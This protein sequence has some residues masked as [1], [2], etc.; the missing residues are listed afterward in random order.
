MKRLQR[1]YYLVGV[2][3]LLLAL[4]A[5]FFF[6]QIASTVK[7][8]PH[9]QINYVIFA[10]IILGSLLMLW[11]VRR[12]NREGDLLRA[13]VNKVRSDGAGEDTR[14]WFESQ[15]D[16]RR[17]D[18]TD[19]LDLVLD[20]HGKPLGQVQ[21]AAIESELQYFH[22]RQ[23]R[24][25]LLAQFL[26]GMMVGMGLLGTFIGLLGALSEIGKLIGSFSI[27][28]SMGDPVEAV[29]LLVG[30][31]TEPMKAMGVAFSASLFGVLGSLIMGMLMVSVRGCMGEL[32]SIVQSRVSWMTDLP[33]D[34]TSE[35]LTNALADLAQHSPLLSG[36]SVALDQSERRVRQ[37]IETITTLSAA[38]EVSGKSQEQIEKQLVAQSQNQ[39]A[40]LDVLRQLSDSQKEAVAI[41]ERSD[42][43]AVEAT[44]LQAQ[45]LTLLQQALTRH[46]PWRETIA[47]LTQAQA[48]QT[49]QMQTR[50]TEGLAAMVEQVR[51]ERT[52]WMGQE[53]AAA[54]E[55][56]QLT[57]T[58]VEAT[59]RA[60]Q[61]QKQVAEYLQQQLSQMQTQWKGGMATLVE[62][63]NQERQHVVDHLQQQLSQM[64]TQWSSG[65][66]TVVEQV[67]QERQQWQAQ[68][69]KTSESQQQLTQTI[70]T[71]V[72][73]FEREQIKLSEQWQQRLLQ[74]GQHQVKWMDAQNQMGVLVAQTQELLHEDSQ[75]R[76]ELSIQM[77]E[78]LGELQT[79]QEQMLHRVLSQPNV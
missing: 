70:L 68:E 7:G 33:A 2:P 67:N 22:T 21:H 75:K 76:L 77:R 54:Q 39:L 61:E 5:I 58:V 66:S 37:L 25:L 57:Q 8:N 69:Q 48:G 30:R 15:T 24:H 50:W 16:V 49:Q 45:Q 23:Q 17:Y 71:L 79:R 35:P 36:L 44:Q 60:S 32:V 31:L 9:P 1:Y 73:N 42:V 6:P 41:H 64:Q 72:Q 12:L 19:V 26:S 52:Q 46:E 38:I 59:Q 63:V 40:V 53:E 51:L 18:V 10:L 29:S 65:M 43:R 62:Q 55:R 28:P 13:F 56:Q 11:H 4:G 34:S 74:Q 14:A 27:G 20:T 47:E 3:L 78:V